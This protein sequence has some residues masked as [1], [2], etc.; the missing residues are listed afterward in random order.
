MYSYM[1][2]LIIDLVKGLENSLIEKL[3]KNLRW[4]KQE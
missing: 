4:N 3:D 2:N 1:P